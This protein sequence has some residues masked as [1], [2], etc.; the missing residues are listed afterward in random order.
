MAC[1]LGMEFETTFWKS[2]QLYQL[3]VPQTECTLS[4]FLLW[5]PV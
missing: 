2:I 1:S 3:P 5:D 4:S